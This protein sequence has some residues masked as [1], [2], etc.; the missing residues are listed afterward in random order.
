MAGDNGILLT[1]G[2][3]GERDVTAT[4]DAV[5]DVVM[6]TTCVGDPDEPR[7]Q[8]GQQLIQFGQQLAQQVSQASQTLT[9]TPTQIAQMPLQQ[10]SQMAQPL[11]SQERE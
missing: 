11:G 7:R 8:G 1:P 2:G 4:T 10:M 9:Q 3:F 6:V 5:G